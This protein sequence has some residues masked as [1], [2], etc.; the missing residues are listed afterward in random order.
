MFSFPTSQT[1]HALSLSLSLSLPTLLNENHHEPI[2]HVPSNRPFSHLPQ[3]R[4]EVSNKRTPSIPRRKREKD[5]RQ[6]MAEVSNESDKFDGFSWPDDEERLKK[7]MVAP[8]VDATHLNLP[9]DRPLRVVC[10]SDTHAK[11]WDYEVGSLSLTI[12]PLNI[13]SLSFPLSFPQPLLTHLPTYPPHHK[14]STL[15]LEGT[16]SST[17]ETLPRELEPRK[18]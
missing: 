11:H 17:Q 2:Q 5:K 10:I 7:C 16:F 18:K 8:S 12:S 4:E 14:H 15:S 3:K 1:S 13:P 9:S 6:I